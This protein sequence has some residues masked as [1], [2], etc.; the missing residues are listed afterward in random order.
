MSISIQSTVLVLAL[1]ALVLFPALGLLPAL[2]A[3]PS[4]LRFIN[5][6]KSL[7]DED[8]PCNQHIAA[9][10]EIDVVGA[11]SDD[12]SEMVRPM[13]ALASQ[14]RSSPTSISKTC[15]QSCE[16]NAAKLADVLHPRLAGT[17]K[18][19]IAA[20]P[21]IAT[22]GD[23]TD[24]RPVELL[25]ADPGATSVYP[26]T[27][28]AKTSCHDGLGVTVKPSK[29][30]GER[31]WTSAGTGTPKTKADADDTS[32]IGSASVA[33]EDVTV[34]ATVTVNNTAPAT[35][36]MQVATLTATTGGGDGLGS[37]VSQTV[38]VT[39]DIQ[40]TQAPT[41]DIPFPP[42]PR[43]TI[44]VTSNTPPSDAAA[45]PS[46]MP[47]TGSGNILAILTPILLLLVGGP[48]IVT[49]RSRRRRIQSDEEA[50]V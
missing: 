35:A 25:L 8:M 13:R 6:S 22:L 5:M 14:P 27:Q 15:H 21:D 44:T 28:R 4:Q 38:T 37:D 42:T 31:M 1:L 2:S 30:T 9:C 10:E 33:H 47:I 12:A 48:V 24:P 49:V 7:L 32:Y 20:P 50:D 36:K 29:N 17:H 3:A 26:E 16:S 41:T 34:T 11:L 43:T 45:A 39:I 18:N 40:P 19:A 46:N 23:H